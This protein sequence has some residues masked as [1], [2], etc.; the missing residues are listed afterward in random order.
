M[1]P[2]AADVNSQAAESVKPGLDHPGPLGLFQGF[3]VEVEY[4][5]TRSDSLEL[6]P[7]ADALLARASQADA[8]DSPSLAPVSEVGRGELAW[9]NELVLHVLEMKTNG[10]A[11]RLDGLSEAFHREVLQ[12]NAWLAPMGC[13]LLPGAVHPWMDPATETR[14]WPH[15]YTEVYRT[16]DRIFGC[17]GHGWSNLQ[18]THLNLPF[19]GDR[20]FVAL[21]SAIRGILPLIPALSAASPILDGRVSHSLDARMRAYAQNAVRVSSVTGAVVPEEVGSRDEYESKILSRIYRDMAPLDPD[22]V[23]RHE[24]V[25]ARGAI[26]RFEREAMEIRIIDAQE[27]PSADLAVVQMVVA[28][29]QPMVESALEQPL[30]WQRLDTASLASL[31]ENTVAKG[32]KAVVVDA[33]LLSLLGMASLRRPS[34]G[35][36]W[37]RLMEGV[38][39]HASSGEKTASRVILD[40][41]PWLEGSWKRWEIPG[42]ARNCPGR[43][44]GKSGTV[45]DAVWQTTRSSFR[46]TSGGR[47]PTAGAFPYLR[48]WG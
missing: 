10:P 35:E 11:S 25:N 1:S 47:L 19:N 39:P 31:L 27:C 3:G 33:Q 29:L 20:E 30:A 41:G 21:H 26:A 12:A 24:W 16:F 23:L 32:E 5:I 45:L 4:M 2:E 22:G 43:H 6:A 14:I 48:A 34:A 40:R 15:E 17:Q 8:D 46:D 42:R 38:A 44:S 18:S 28:A 7:V 36:V 37:H 13:R 9:S